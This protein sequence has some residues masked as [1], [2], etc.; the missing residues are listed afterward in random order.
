VAAF[1]REDH[2]QQHP[3]D[4]PPR[5]GVEVQQPAVG[6]HQLGDQRQAQARAI[7]LGGDERLEQVLAQ[8]G[9]D[10]GAVV[11]DA[12]F[13]RG[14]TQRLALGGADA[15]AVAVGGGDG[16]LAAA[17]AAR[18]GRLGGVLH[19][20]QEDLDQ[21]VLVAQHRRQRGVVLL[22]QAEAVGDAVGGQGAHPVQ[23][24]VDV[25]RLQERQGVVGEGLH[26]LDEAA[27]AV[28]LVDDQLGERG[29]LALGAGLQELC[30]AADA[31]QRVLDLVRPHPAQAHDGAQ[32]AGDL[33]A[34]AF[35]AQPALHRKRQHH[36]AVAQRRGRPVRLER[37]QAEEGDLHAALAHPRPLRD[38]PVQQGHQRRAWRQGGGEVAA[39]EQA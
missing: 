26:A 22:P 17:V 4:G 14:P 39:A 38:G 33:G 1:I 21:L 24:L 5:L 34:G 11:D 29:V 10:A 31:G 7:G 30:S 6:R 16:D 25:E 13:Q 23:H 3:E 8:V 35:G 20:V 27:H 2:R 15:H 32:P 36:R 9:R 28:G 19:Q 12:H 18:M 37:R